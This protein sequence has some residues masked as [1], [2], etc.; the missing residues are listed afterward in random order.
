MRTKTTQRGTHG[1]V[2]EAAVGGVFKVEVGKREHDLMSRFDGDL[3]DAVGPRRIAV[4]IVVGHYHSRTRRKLTAAACVQQT[5]V[6][7]FESLRSVQV[8]SAKLAAV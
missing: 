4:W 6:R 2:V 5:I 3:P 1:Q 7:C 8:S